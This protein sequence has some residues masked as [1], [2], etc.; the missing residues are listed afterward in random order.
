MHIAIYSYK[1]GDRKQMERLTAREAD[2]WIKEGNPI[3]SYTFGSV[4]SLLASTLVYDAVLID[5][6]ETDTVDAAGLI[7][8]YRNNKMKTRVVECA[9][10]RTHEDDG[11]YFFLQKE[12]KKDDLHNVLREIYGLKNED[13]VRIELRTEAETFYV[14][15]RDIMYAVQNLHNME[16]Y[17]KDGRIITMFGRVEVFYA[18]I[19]KAHPTIVLPAPNTLVNIRYIKLLGFLKIFMKDGRMV[20]IK[21]AVVPYIKEVMKALESGDEEALKTLNDG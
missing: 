12:I 17:L 10:E 15:E 19:E 7:E 1:V 14:E 3:Y 2:R 4:E 13:S 9:E 6:C 21:H 11:D 8:I 18:E 20:R 5:L 16:I